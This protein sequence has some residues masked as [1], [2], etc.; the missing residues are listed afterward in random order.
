LEPAVLVVDQL[1]FSTDGIKANDRQIQ[2][3]RGAL[4]PPVSRRPNSLPGS[5]LHVSAFQ[6]S[7]RWSAGVVFGRLRV[8]EQSVASPPVSSPVIWQ[9]PAQSRNSA[10]EPPTPALQDHVGERLLLAS[11]HVGLWM[12]AELELSRAHGE[13]GQRRP[14]LRGTKTAAAAS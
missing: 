1:Q 10:V 13:D 11:R 14:R 3:D 8:A 6:N 5:C 9:P 2:Q 12:R 7:P 4:S